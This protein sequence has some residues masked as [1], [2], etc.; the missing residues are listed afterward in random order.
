[1]NTI[2]PNK[3]S[4]TPRPHKITDKEEYKGSSCE[5]GIFFFLICT[6]CGASSAN[7]EISRECWRVLIYTQLGTLAVLCFRCKTSMIS[8]RIAAG[9][10]NPRKLHLM[11]HTPVTTITRKLGTGRSNRPLQ[12]AWSSLRSDWCKLMIL[13]KSLI[14]LEE[15]IK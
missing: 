3:I 5:L 2:C 13:G 11:F 8:A 15:S 14:I 1:M 6:K 4:S 10:M 7:S 12:I 9:I